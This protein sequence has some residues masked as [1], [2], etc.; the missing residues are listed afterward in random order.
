MCTQ[1][2]FRIQTNSLQRSDGEEEEDGSFTLSP[3]RHGSCPETDL[4]GWE[5]LSLPLPIT[6]EQESEDGLAVSLGDL[7]R[8]MHPYCI[9]ISVENEIGEHLLPEGGILLEV[10]DQG[11][12][13]EPILAIQNM[14]LPSSEPLKEMSLENQGKVSDEAEEEPSDSSEQIVVDDDDED[15][16]LLKNKCETAAMLTSVLQSDVKNEVVFRRPKEKKTKTTSRR[17]RKKKSEEE[18]QPK[19]VEGRVLRSGTVSK[20]AQKIQKK[21]ERELIKEEKKKKV[22]SVSLNSPQSLLNSNEMKPCRTKMQTDNTTTASLTVRNEKAAPLLSPTLDSAPSSTAEKNQP[23]CSAESSQPHK[24]PEQPVTPCVEAESSSA[25]PSVPPSLVSSESPTAAPSSE[26][27]ET[28]PSVNAVLPAPEP[29]PKS[30]SLDEYRRLRQQKKP[31]P[32]GNPDKN[33]TK[34]PTLPELPREL[35]PIP[36]LPDPNP[37]DPRRPSTLVA[38]REVEEVKPAWQPRGPGAPPTPEALLV[39]PAYMVSSSSK[40]ASTAAVHKPPQTQEPSKLPEKPQTLCSEKSLA[41]HPQATVTSP[42]SCESAA[43]LKPANH[44]TS[45]SEGT[46]SGV[47]GNK[48]GVD[49]SAQSQSMSLKSG[50]PTKICPVTK[51]AAGSGLAP[52]APLKTTISQK[53]PEVTASTSLTDPKRKSSKLAAGSVKPSPA[54]LTLNTC[55]PKTHCVMLETK[56]KSTNQKPKDATQ[57]LI[58]AFAGEIGEVNDLQH[59][60][61]LEFLNI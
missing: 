28:A 7:V 49:D 22:P 23:E 20:P 55:T 38:K 61:L 25:S 3:D 16:V 10:V 14:D 46:L 19:P 33:I 4:F 36:C 40:V 45:S 54:A 31:A 48:V 11:E 42:V 34:W 43:S 37:K 17:K 6:F 52:S 39:P 47:S 13:G 9:P 29:K 59:Q 60:L 56:E 15:D 35:P 41:T 8:H 5:G 24:P 44:S 21:P 51:P 26:V 58:E 18:Q 12:N 57:E 50:D 32:V 1:S 53:L 2:L 30:L 27:P